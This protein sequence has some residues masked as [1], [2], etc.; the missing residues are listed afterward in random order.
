MQCYISRI[1]APHCTILSSPIYN[2]KIAYKTNSVP[3]Y[4]RTRGFEEW[5]NIDVLFFDKYIFF[6]FLFCQIYD[7]R[8]LHKNSKSQPDKNT[9]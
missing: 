7:I 5:L 1:R 4:H 3:A 6:I 8:L 2:I 9:N